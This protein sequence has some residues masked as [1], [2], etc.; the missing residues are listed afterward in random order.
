MDDDDDRDGGGGAVMKAETNDTADG[1]SG[2]SPAIP[3]D[4]TNNTSNSAISIDMRSDDAR[5]VVVV[6]RIIV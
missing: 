4:V 3:P 1:L 2:P 6:G 5:V